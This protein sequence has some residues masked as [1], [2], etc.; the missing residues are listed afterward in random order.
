[1]FEV[2]VNDK[3]L[4]VSVHWDGPSERFVLRSCSSILYRA[5]ES[6]DHD[7]WDYVSRNQLIRVAT[8]EGLVYSN[9]S[10]WEPKIRKRDAD[11]G[12]LSVL[13]PVSELDQAKQEKG[14]TEGQRPWPDN[15]VFGILETKLLPEVL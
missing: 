12:L 5:V 8:T 10:F 14:H 9:R 2:T 7:F 11:A 4:I 1:K 15:T 3:K 6:P 13:T